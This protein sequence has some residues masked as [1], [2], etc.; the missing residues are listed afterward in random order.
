MAITVAWRKQLSVR[1]D[2]IAPNPASV[3]EHMS[4]LVGIFTIPL[5][6]WSKFLPSISH[7]RACEKMC[8]MARLGN[9][10]WFYSCD[11][12]YSSPCE[13]LASSGQTCG[14]LGILVAT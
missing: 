1:R 14:G 6:R 9:S 10:Y 11:Y 8:A 12:A 7:R 13:L 3:F 2:R 5:K 4:T